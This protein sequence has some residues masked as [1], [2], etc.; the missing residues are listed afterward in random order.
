M[1]RAEWL[2]KLRAQNEALYDHVAPA[3]WVKFGLYDNPVHRQF[4]DK[5]LR[6]LSAPGFLLD[7]ACGA[8]RY[9]GMLLEA[10]HTVLGIDQASDMLAQ[11][12]QHF[13]QERFP[14]LRYVRIGLQEMD[15]REE[16]DGA[17][18]VDALEHVS[19]ED[20]PGIMA[21][22]YRALKPGGVLY[23]TVE[24]PEGDE[25]RV[26]YERAT[27]LGLPVVFGEIV[28]NIDVVYPKIMAQDWQEVDGEESDP[29]VYHFLPSLE[30]A[31]AWLDQ[32]GLVIEEEGSGK[33]YT[34]FLARKN[35]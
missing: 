23:I 25:A 35:A 15:F 30:Q 4:I 18:C 13:P 26:A 19:P 1:E 33:W 6:R 14:R 8:G 12:R 10:G 5:F 32:A 27:A 29:A 17:I 11:A 16:F 9:D 20:W 21:R 31:R 34:H 24:P 22:F 7:A 3:F 2:K 28:D